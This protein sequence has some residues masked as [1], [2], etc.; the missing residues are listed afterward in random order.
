M[1]QAKEGQQ[2]AAKAKREARQAVLRQ[3][4][5]VACTLAAAGGELASL[6]GNA[7]HFD[8]L[9]IDEV[10]QLAMCGGTA[11]NG[12]AVYVLR[13]AQKSCPCMAACRS[14]CRIRSHTSSA[15]CGMQPQ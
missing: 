14:R 11:D 15:S 9:I 13:T 7:L 12:L 10:P 4:E 6:L 5:V 1:S 2:Q 8:G 3:A